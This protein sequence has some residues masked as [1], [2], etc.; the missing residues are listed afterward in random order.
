MQNKITKNISIIAIL[1]AFIG[2]SIGFAAYSGTLKIEHRPSVPNSKNFKVRFSSND[3]VT[4]EGVVSSTS[5]KGAKAEQAVINNDNTEVIHKC[6]SAVVLPRITGLNAIFTKPGQNVV[7]KFYIRNDGEF[8]AYLKSI[9][10]DKKYC[11]LSNGINNKETKNA[12]D[13]INIKIN[14]DGMEYNKTDDMIINQSIKPGTSVPISVEINYDK[15]SKFSFKQNL[16]VYFGEIS[17]IYSAI[18]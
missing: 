1:V 7:Y 15:N 10:F 9:V 14:I 6:E 3:I 12:C 4:I 17:L 11:K 13:D 8:N 2:L 18:K 16:E 5:S